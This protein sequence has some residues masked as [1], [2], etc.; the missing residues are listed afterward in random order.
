MP[1]LADLL[2]VNVFELDDWNYEGEDE[3]TAAVV[4]K[5]VITK[6]SVTV[7]AKYQNT[8]VKYLCNFLAAAISVLKIFT[9][10]TVIVSYIKGGIGKDN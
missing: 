6:V 9:V 10:S 8:C 3:D 4:N 1:T 7:G 2:A 5:T